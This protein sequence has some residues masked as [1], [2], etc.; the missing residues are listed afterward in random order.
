MSPTAHAYLAHP[1]EHWDFSVHPTKRA[2]PLKTIGESFSLSFFPLSRHLSSKQIPEIM[3]SWLTW[4]LPVVN[5]KQ[6]RTSSLGLCLPSLYSWPG[7][8]LQMPICPGKGTPLPTPPPNTRISRGRCE[9][10][11]AGGFVTNAWSCL[12]SGRRER[13][14]DGGEALDGFLPSHLV[15]VVF[16]IEGTV[17]LGGRG[18][19]GSLFKAWTCQNTLQHP[20]TGATALVWLEEGRALSRVE[21]RDQ[22]L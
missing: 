13:Q 15:A 14:G 19:P 10:W 17:A 3:S 7:R 20:L 6:M 22:N 21:Q 1:L 16:S 12:G 5:M 11:D 8:S 9:R 18:F 2:L 4:S